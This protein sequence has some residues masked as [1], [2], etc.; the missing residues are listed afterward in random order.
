[1]LEGYNRPLPNFCVILMEADLNHVLFSS[2]FGGSYNCPTLQVD[3]RLYP[4][5][6]YYLKHILE[7][8]KY[9][10][11]DKMNPR[12]SDERTIIYNQM[13]ENLQNMKLMSSKA[14]SCN[15]HSTAGVTMLMAAAVRGEIEWAEK[16]LTYGADL[17]IKSKYEDYELSA[18]DWA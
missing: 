8:M 17:N 14:P 12:Q 9:E 1:M 4:V 6:T 15:G 3:G 13:V 2:F 11:S 7:M 18:S 16:L 10:S 5:D